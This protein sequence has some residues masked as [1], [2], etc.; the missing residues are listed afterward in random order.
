MLE[1]TIKSIK[2]RGGK[3]F[4]QFPRNSIEIFKQNPDSEIPSNSIYLVTS[5]EP[6][7]LGNLS[8]LWLEMA[9]RVCKGR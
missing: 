1:S 6:K 8:K 9:D 3:I 5:C 7:R 2:F 4:Y